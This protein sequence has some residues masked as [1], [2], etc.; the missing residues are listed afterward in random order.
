ME[1]IFCNLPINFLDL[2]A[3][4]DPSLQKVFKCSQN[5]LIHRECLEKRL[6]ISTK[7]QQCGEEYKIKILQTLGIQSNNSMNK[8][9]NSSIPPSILQLQKNL[10][11]LTQKLETVKQKEHQVKTQIE[12]IQT[13]KKNLQNHLLAL[14]KK[15][16]SAESHLNLIIQEMQ[17][18]ETQIQQFEKALP[19]EFSQVEDS[20]IKSRNKK[21]N[22]KQVSWID[23]IDQDLESSEKKRIETRNKLNNVLLTDK[24]KIKKEE[25]LQA[26]EIVTEIASRREKQFRAEAFDP[27]L[28][29]EFDP[30]NFTASLTRK[31]KEKK[32]LEAQPKSKTIPFLEVTS[33]NTKEMPGR[34][35]KP[36]FLHE[37]A[38]NSNAEENNSIPF[39]K[40]VK[41]HTH[42]TQTITIP[43][44]PK[45]P[46]TRPK[47]KKI[48]QIDKKPPVSTTSMASTQTVNTKIPIKSKSPIETTSKVTAKKII[49]KSTQNKAPLCVICHSPIENNESEPRDELIECPNEHP[50]HRN[51]L[52]M[53]IV[54]SDLCPVCHEPYHA[55]ILQSFA[56]F[57]QENAVKKQEEEARKQEE[58][59]HREQEELLKQINPEFT[60]KYN[61][62]DGLMKSKKFPEA[63]TLF[64]EI[65]DANYFPPQDQRILRTF[66]NI[67][68]IYYKQGKHAQAIKQLMKIVK[69]DFNFPLAFYFL[70]LSY[71][72]LGMVEKMTWALERALK[73][74][75]K[76]SEENPKYAKFVTDIERRLKQNP[77]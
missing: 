74:T 73:N 37:D 5:H 49:Q 53:W 48:E 42:E 21:E 47:V 11:E 6:L 25:E 45:L 55:E 24:Q 3:S 44:K 23:Q 15:E 41:S 58:Q 8:K 50:A 69:I 32:V 14:E 36:S 66:L 26:R 52:K 56:D 60:Q 9:D 75:Q 57:K 4:T 62:A 30:L 77:V 71:D 20:Q 61:K 31:V 76:L 34:I 19:K 51:C 33:K 22:Q 10:V 7:C 28:D 64:W 63:L 27:G 70:G 29:D 12:E 39:V 40:E 59:M 46:P 1:C 17:G 16:I 43:A 35:S 54:H 38:Q 67:G 13:E 2:S 18:I 65:I 68:L 72:Q